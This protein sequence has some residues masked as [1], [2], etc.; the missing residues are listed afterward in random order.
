MEKTVPRILFLTHLIFISWDF[1]FEPLYMISSWNKRTTL[2]TRSCVAIILS[3]GVVCGNFTITVVDGG[4]FLQLAVRRAIPLVD[5]LVMHRHGVYSGRRLINMNM[6][7][8]TF[9]C[10][11]QIRKSKKGIGQTALLATRSATSL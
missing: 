8:K 2:N 4:G 10:P 1:R 5:V 7:C 6:R 11:S 3:S 9:L